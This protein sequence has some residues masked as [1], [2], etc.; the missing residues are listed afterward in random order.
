MTR[1]QRIEAVWRNTHRDFKGTYE[2]ERTIMVYRNGTCLVRLSD[3]S[4]QEIAD[5]LPKKR[6][7]R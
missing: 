1:E 7:G 2:G 3:L 6:E 5:R 4:D